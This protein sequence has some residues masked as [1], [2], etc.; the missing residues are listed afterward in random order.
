MGV[1]NKGFTF[2][3]PGNFKHLQTLTAMTSIRNERVQ[4]TGQA[5]AAKDAARTHD[6][7]AGSRNGIPFVPV[8]RTDAHVAQMLSPAQ[9]ASQALPAR[10][11]N[12]SDRR[13]S[14]ETAPT[15]KSPAELFQNAHTQG[16][17]IVQ[18]RQGA[19]ALVGGKANWSRWS[20]GA[21]PDAKTK[22]MAGRVALAS[23]EEGVSDD[24]MAA[25][26]TPISQQDKDPRDPH[27][28]EDLTEALRRLASR[29]DKEAIDH[30]LNDIMAG[31]D[32]TSMDD[33][34]RTR[35]LGEL[36]DANKLGHEEIITKLRKL[37]GFKGLHQEG[38]KRL[39]DE[40]RQ[41]VLDEIGNQ[42]HDGHEGARAL[43]SFNAA[44]S[45]AGLEDPD[46]YIKTYADLVTQE[47]TF[48]SAT[49]LLVHRFPLEALTR[50]G[51]L[52]KLKQ[53]VAE[54]LGSAT[55]LRNLRWIY[56]AAS[57]LGHLK[58]LST[59]IE[60]VEGLVQQVGRTPHGQS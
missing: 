34:D 53:A 6:K 16:L 37:Q 60:F 54:D 33:T 55:S 23:L 36:R 32:T 22:L 49:A 14:P 3:T 5:Q 48:N 8:Q 17:D 31:M 43:A 15:R 44:P 21:K 46:V 30:F 26:L 24:D 50:G 2:G 27:R 25:M 51:V 59:L 40:I 39:R 4:S 7:R 52:N 11:V 47:H 42:V 41:Q 38:Q 28:P 29:D 35:L 58:I 10:N 12:A 57:D 9:D 1:A 20:N 18:V 45:A 13:V 56:E 19:R